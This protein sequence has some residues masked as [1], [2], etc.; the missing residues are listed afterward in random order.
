MRQY[1]IGF[2]LSIYLTM[3]AYLMVV[4]HLFNGWVLV[5]AIVGLA[6]IQLVV[7]LVFFLH[8][9]RD[10]W[11]LV[12]FLF[13]LMVVVIVVAGSLWIMANLDYHHGHEH[14]TPD[15]TNQFIIKDE[16]FKP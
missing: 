8:L 13:M 12:I 16:G 10:R 7:Q 1:V 11:N 14:G 5:A 6:L 3:T 9:G 2:G 4:N 15:Q